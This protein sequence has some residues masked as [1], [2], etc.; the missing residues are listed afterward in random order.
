MRRK[1]LIYVSDSAPPPIIRD[2]LMSRYGLVVVSD[3]VSECLG[4]EVI[5]LSGDFIHDVL[6]L[7]KEVLKWGGADVV[8]D[9]GRAYGPTVVFTVASVAYDLISRYLIRLGSDYVE[10][11]PSLTHSLSGRDARECRLRII[12]EVRK[13]RC[14]RINELASKLGL[15]EATLLRHIYTLSK[16]GL[17]KRYGEVVC[18]PYTVLKP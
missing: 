11:T 2:S 18:R 16:S 1:V 3:G 9:V 7:L 17:V 13:F 14:L 10:V 15:T 6:N 4:C 5:R 12:E 8:I